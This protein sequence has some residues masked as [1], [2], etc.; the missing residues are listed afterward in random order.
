MIGP[1]G[2]GKTTLFSCILGISSL[3]SGEISIFNN[4]TAKS[5]NL[6]KIPSM[7]GYMP[8]ETSLVEELTVL[9]NLRFFANLY[10]MEKME[11]EGRYEV[12]RKVLELPSDDQKVLTCSGGQKR[13]ISF[14]IAILCEP[15]L[16]FLDE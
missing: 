5:Q 2:A 15:A 10:E 8:Q 6:A 3:D 14:A 13:R 7:V 1:S 9:E 11:F 16:L 4:D 12:L